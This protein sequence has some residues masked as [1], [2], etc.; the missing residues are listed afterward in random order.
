MIQ[1]GEMTELAVLRSVNRGLQQ[2]VADAQ[3]IAD[4][5][6]REAFEAG[7]Q[8]G[9][10]TWTTAAI[11]GGVLGAIGGLIGFLIVQWFL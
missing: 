4:R 1:V 5:R 9:T 3:A 10:M 8:R 2:Q 11:I 6:A 7:V